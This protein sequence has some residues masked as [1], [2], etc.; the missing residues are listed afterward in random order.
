MDQVVEFGSLKDFRCDVVAIAVKHDVFEH[1][2]LLCGVLE[3]DCTNFFE[4]LFG[5]SLYGFLDDSRAELLLA[6]LAQIESDEFVE[7]ADAYIH[8]LLP[9]RDCAEVIENC[10]NNEVAKLIVDEVF[11]ALRGNSYKI[12]LCLS[13]GCG[14]AVFNDLTTVLVLCNLSKLLHD[15]FIY[16]RAQ[17]VCL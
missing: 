4:L 7:A 3:E 11:D 15:R 12:L 1:L 14:D 17:L 2:A 16:D 13:L 6:E 10:L 8:L 5:H 9:L